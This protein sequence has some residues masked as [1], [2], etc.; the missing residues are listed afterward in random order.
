MLYL[1]KFNLHINFSLFSYA[2][3][4]L[5]HTL[6]PCDSGGSEQ[7]VQKGSS[8][9][10]A[11]DSN[12]GDTE[13]GKPTDFGK[14]IRDDEGNVIQIEMMSSNKI[15]DID[16]NAIFK[17]DYPTE[18]MEQENAELITSYDAQR[19]K[20]LLASNSSSG[21][22]D[23]QTQANHSDVTRGK[24]VCVFPADFPIKIYFTPSEFIERC[25]MTYLRVSQSI[26]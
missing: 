15:I 23:G 26:E 25:L 12:V 4:G 22:T 13:S 10:E 6:N 18:E 7:R 19:S 3:L 1:L 11:P 21:V 8:A 9:G 20:W 5:T 24:C 14:I 16:K 17:E 2:A